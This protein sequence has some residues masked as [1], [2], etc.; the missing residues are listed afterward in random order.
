MREGRELPHSHQIL[1]DPVHV[2]TDLGGVVGEE[3]S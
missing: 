1:Q 2:L 3:E